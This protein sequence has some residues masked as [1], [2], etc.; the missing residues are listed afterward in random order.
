MQLSTV[1]EQTPQI[2][3]QG[4]AVLLLNI[5]EPP[6]KELLGRFAFEF[7]PTYIVFDKTG[8]EVFRLNQLP[9]VDTIVNA[10]SS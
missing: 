6:G 10:A 7:S 3:K 8:E 4:V 9:S 5:H 2:Q 1:R